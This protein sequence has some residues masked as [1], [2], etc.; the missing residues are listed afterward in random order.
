M[1]ARF[2]ALIIDTIV[3]SVIAF[4][5]GLAL[6]GYHFH[7]SKTCDAAGVCTT[8]FRTGAGAGTNLLSA[9]VG[10]LYFTLL[11]GLASQTLGHRIAGVRVVNVGTGAPIGIA[12]GFVRWLVM[13]VTGLL[14][15]LGYWSPFFDRNRRGWHDKASGAIAITAR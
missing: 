8:Q 12:R 6:G 13:T 7:T 15:T 3:V 5:L 2:G 11:V 10:L 9:L 1:G 4:L 14:L